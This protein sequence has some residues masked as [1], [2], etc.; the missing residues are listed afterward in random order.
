MRD[1]NDLESCC[2]DY[3]QETLEEDISNY[4]IIS[5]ENLYDEETDIVYLSLIH[6]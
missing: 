4:E 1:I 2:L 3:I 5:S 6:I